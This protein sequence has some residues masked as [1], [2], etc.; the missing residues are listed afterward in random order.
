MRRERCEKDRCQNQAVERFA[1]FWLC[2]EHLCPEPESSYFKW[3]IE[4]CAGIK[5]NCIVLEDAIVETIDLNGSED[6]L[7]IMTG[8]NELQEEAIP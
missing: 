7:S 4:L 5:S 3:E 2:R 1:G 6:C 8:E